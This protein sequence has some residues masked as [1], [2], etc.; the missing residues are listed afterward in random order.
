MYLSNFMKLKI[1]Y[2]IFFMMLLSAVSIWSINIQPE[3]EIIVNIDSLQKLYGP[4]DL[5][6]VNVSFENSGDSE[7]VE[8]VGFPVTKLEYIKPDSSGW[9]NIK[10]YKNSFFDSSNGSEFYHINSGEKLEMQLFLLTD[11][12]LVSKLNEFGFIFYETGEYKI[13]VSHKTKNG[14]TV[15]SNT[16]TLSVKPYDGP[17]YTAYQWIKLQSKPYFFYDFGTYLSTGDPQLI[18][19]ARYILRNFPD[20]K[21]TPYVQ[22][23]LARVFLYGIRET[24]NSLYIPDLEKAK[25]FAEQVLH[26]DDYV[27]INEA[28]K[29]IRN[30]EKARYSEANK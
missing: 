27:L 25:F 26:V 6:T 7:R 2:K 18:A 5:V 10:Y 24:K 30:V 29:V 20:S 4:I 21:F 1:Y 23:F 14:K 16:L 17:D 12:S 19:N 3:D 8:S 9:N 28:Q 22:L 11:F 13:R 15:Y